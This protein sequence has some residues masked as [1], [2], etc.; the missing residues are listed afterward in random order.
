MYVCGA[1][2]LQSCLFETPW[3]VAHQAPLSIGFSRQEYWS[4]QPSPSPGDLPRSEIKP[5]SPALAGGFFITEPPGKPPCVMLEGIILLQRFMIKPTILQ[6]LHISQF[7]HLNLPWCVCYVCLLCLLVTQLHPT[8]CDPMD[9]SGLLR[10][11]DSP[12]K[13][14]RELPFPSPMFKLRLN[15]SFSYHLLCYYD[16]RE[17][18]S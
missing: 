9:S 6:E 1:K 11:W 17:T 14:T 13:N 4:G 3:T 5:L 12:G 18:R 8:L 15:S 2:P 7:L 10:P 16:P